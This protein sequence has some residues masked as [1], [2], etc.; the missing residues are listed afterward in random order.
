MGYEALP[1]RYA[2]GVESDLPVQPPLGLVLGAGGARGFAH[3]GVLKVLA[4]HGVYFDLVVGASMGSL[5]G[6]AH[7]AGLGMEQVERLVLD[8]RIERL[9][10]FQPGA[11]SF[12]NPSALEVTL[13][14]AFADR[15][16][17]DLAVPFA[18]VAT[19]LTSGKLAILREGPLVPALLAAVAIPLVFPPVRLGDVWLADGGMV[20]GLPVATARQLGAARVL[21]V[22]AD[23]HALRPLNGQWLAPLA[24]GARDWLLRGPWTAPTH[25]QV[26]GRCLHCMLQD[27]PEAEPDV[28]IRPLF[29]RMTS[30]HYHRRAHTIALGE[31]AARKALPHVLALRG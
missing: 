6:A 31:A 15:T 17:A 16:F 5:V 11:A 1:L 22:D 14:T 10:R 28:L 4:Q 2:R 21:A 20:D 29:G 7:A 30:N 3:I 9:L 25:V 27:H 26:L 19:D 23:N 12:I 24:E 8:L 13:R 18:A